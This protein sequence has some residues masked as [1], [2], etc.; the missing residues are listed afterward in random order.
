M[1]SRPRRSRRCLESSIRTGADTEV[2]EELPWL[3]QLVM[4]ERRPRTAKPAAARRLL[5]KAYREYDEAVKCY[6]NALRMERESM[7][8]LRDLAA[9]QART[10]L[11]HPGLCTSWSLHKQYCCLSRRVRDANGGE[12][13]L[14]KLLCPC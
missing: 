12:H 6:K 3:P 14:S 2:A 10:P 9:L 5:Y 11:D 13:G 8:V 1:R 7:Q 4:R